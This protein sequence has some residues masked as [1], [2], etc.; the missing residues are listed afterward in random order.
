MCAEQFSVISKILYKQYE[1][2]PFGSLLQEEE[3]KIKESLKVVHRN[4]FTASNGYLKPTSF[5][6][7]THINGEADYVL[8]P[9]VA[10]LT[11][12]VGKKG[13]LNCLEVTSWK[14]SGKW[15]N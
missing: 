15:M 9:T 4:S 14:T 11:V 13:S 3:L 5:I 6:P 7:E 8:L 2:L 1:K 10:P 12:K